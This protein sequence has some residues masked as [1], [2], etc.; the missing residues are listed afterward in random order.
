MSSTIDQRIR[1]GEVD[2]Q[3]LYTAGYQSDAAKELYEELV[4]SGKQDTTFRRF[5]RNEPFFKPDGIPPYRILKFYYVPERRV[6]QI[7]YLSSESPLIRDGIISENSGY[8]LGLNWRSFRKPNVVFALW[9]QKAY[10]QDFKQLEQMSEILYYPAFNWK[11][12][13]HDLGHVGQILSPAL[14][15]IPGF[16]TVASNIVG[17]MSKNLS[18]GTT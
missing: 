7:E 8:K 2:P 17:Q 6:F 15:L 3:S 12:L 1:M 14:N 11:G 18:Y 5:L 9:G 16:G 10:F 13:L 4:L